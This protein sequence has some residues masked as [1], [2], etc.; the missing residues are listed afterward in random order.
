MKH[1]VIIPAHNEEA[2][3]KQ[4]L[5]AIDQQTVVPDMAMVVDD[6]ST[7]R[8]GLLLDKYSR[9]YSWCQHISTES[10]A[11][12][13]PGSK[14][15][16]A[17]NAGLNELPD[18][19]DVITKLDADVILPKAYFEKVLEAFKNDPDLGI[20][21][22]YIYEQNKS[23][24]W[25]KHHPM[26]KEHVRGAMKSYRGS[27]FK[28]IDGLRNDIGWDTVDELLARYHNY[29]VNPIETLKVKHLRPLGSKYPKKARRL[30][31]RAMYVMRYGLFITVIASV[32]MAWKHRNPM[33]II[34]N[35]Q[36][37]FEAKEK[38]APPLVTEEEGKFIRALRWEGIRKKL[39]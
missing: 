15:I 28:A 8:T 23:G 38:S 19:Y 13:L 39:F 18:D 20:T 24:E 32:K 7:D 25:I 10:T 9:Q 30:Q 33:I 36:G 16:N 37:Y 22:G 11:V 2:F 4:V 12:H 29:T 35:L 34:H 5:E 31:G 21:G 14:V 1:Y 17:F 3:L 27:C 26:A 6:N